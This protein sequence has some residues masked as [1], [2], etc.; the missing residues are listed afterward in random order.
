MTIPFLGNACPLSG[1]GF[2]QTLQTL[3]VDAASLWALLPVETRGFGYMAD[4]R[5]KILF[6][7]HVFH[8][9]TQ[10]RFG[11]VASDVSSPDPGG[12]EGGTREYQGP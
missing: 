11:G 5:P 6:E 2:E 4:R 9:R 7:R 8:R 10:G 1:D 12:Y 3:G